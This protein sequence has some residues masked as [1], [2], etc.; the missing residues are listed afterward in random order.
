MC[1]CGYGGSAVIA[2]LVALIEIGAGVALIIGLLTVPAA[3]GIL[4]IM[5]FAQCCEPP[6][7][8]RKMQIADR[9]DAVAK[10]LLFCE[11]LYFTMAGVTMLMGPG[12]WSLDWYLFGG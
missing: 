3:F 1:S 5:A 8:M 4:V 6:E 2:A 9:V 12:K 10:F 7:E 11:P